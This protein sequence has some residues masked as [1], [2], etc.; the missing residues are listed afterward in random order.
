MLSISY[1]YRESPLTWLFSVCLVFVNA[2]SGEGYISVD[3]NEGDRK[4]ITLWKNGEQVIKNVTA[5]CN[6]TVVVMHTV[7]PV[8]VTDWYENPNI[9]AILWAGL[10]GQESGNSLVDVL[11]GRVNPGGKTPFTWGKSREAYG[12]PLLVEPNN[13]IGAPQDDFTEGVFVDYR[14][15]DKYNETP[16]YEFG[17]GL[18]YT[19]FSYSNLVV[20]PLNPMK[21]AP[22]TGTTGPAPSLGKPGD[23]SEYLYPEGL[24]RVQKFLYPWLNSTDLQKSSADRDYGMDASEY[25]PAGATDGSAQPIHPAGGAP[26]GNP[27][28][29]DELFWVSATITNT[30]NVLGDEVPQLVRSVTDKI[31]FIDFLLT[32]GVYSTFPWA[33]PMTPRSSSAA[34]TVSPSALNSRWYGRPP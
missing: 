14:R 5:N 15:F 31:R 33:A 20:Q 2:D 4:N 24:N 28:L 34:S 32:Y 29:Y 25:I 9:T 10:P 21:Y 19:T 16:I 11:Y 23:D 6:N 22:V 8:V 26:G 12:N 1:H 27:G 18:S 13:G 17:F 7:G 30:G 3:G